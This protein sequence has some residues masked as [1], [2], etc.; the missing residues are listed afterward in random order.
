M[1]RKPR[2]AIVV[3]HPIQHF[4][5]Q[6]ASFASSG[7]FQIKFSSARPWGL[8]PTSIRTLRIEVSWNN[9]YLDRFDHV[10]LNGD[11][12]LP[13]DQNL[14]APSLESA[15]TGFSPD[16]VVI[17]GYFQKLQR[18]A[19]SW[20][21]RNRVKIAYI[22]DS[23][24]RQKRNKFRALIKWFVIRAIFS[25]IDLFLSVGDANEEYYR[26]YGVGAKRI[27]RMHFPID[28]EHY[29]AAIHSKAELRSRVRTAYGIDND[30][31]VLIVVGKL[32]PWKCQDHIIDALQLL[33]KR[34]VTSHLLIVGSGEME[35]LWKHQAGLLK[36][37]KA[38]FV[39]FVSAEELPSY[40]AASDI[41]VHPAMREPHSIAISEAIFMGCSV[42]ISDR[43]G[44]YGPTDDVQKNN[45]LVYPWGDI[46]IARF[47]YRNVDNRQR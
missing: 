47:R 17:Y 8:N 41:Y 3:S 38:Y 30:K 9:L 32:V 28:V 5:P 27:V 15:L 25:K 26:H 40:Y 22:S 44:S 11:R 39:G 37:S 33:E 1:N 36:K 18:R 4:C 16:V 31:P 43:C 7:V 6:Y 35:D 12:V 45:G 20:A 13:S 21:V 29:A 10:F 19:R 23:E 46:L 34:N 2:L 42:I 24:L 14:D